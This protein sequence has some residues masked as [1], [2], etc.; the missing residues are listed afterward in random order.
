MAAKEA[1]M[2]LRMDS[3]VKERVEALYRRMGTTF[4][5]AIRMFAAQS[6]LENRMPFQPAAAVEDVKYSNP[7][8]GKLARFAIP[9]L[10]SL[11]D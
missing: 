10:I 7:L 5:D 4:A 6:L 3:D 11:V 1:I 2:Q 8:R 9:A